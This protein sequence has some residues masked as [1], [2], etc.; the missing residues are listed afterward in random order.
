MGTTGIQNVKEGELEV[1]GSVLFSNQG[2]RK[3]KMRT[4]R[5]KIVQGKTGLLWRH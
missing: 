4:G 3:R 2:E 1:G 5:G